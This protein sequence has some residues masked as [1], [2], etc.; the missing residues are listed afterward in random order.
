VALARKRTIL[1]EPLPL[2]S[3]VSANF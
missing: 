2:V 3:K 1:T